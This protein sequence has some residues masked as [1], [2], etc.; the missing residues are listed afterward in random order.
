M[1][2]I[3]NNTKGEASEMENQ[4]IHYA[5]SDAIHYPEIYDPAEGFKLTSVSEMKVGTWEYSLEL[6]NGN[7]EQV[8]IESIK[9]HK[10]KNCRTIRFSR[11]VNIKDDPFDPT[12]VSKTIHRNMNSPVFI[13]DMD[14]PA[15]A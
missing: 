1:K 4:E 9:V 11:W 5:Q 14:H 7:V 12:L 3:T 13:Q 6:E 2:Q 15:Y 10:I 8:Y